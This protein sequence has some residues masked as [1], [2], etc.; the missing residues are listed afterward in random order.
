VVPKG[1]H[2]AS[3]L[4]PRL[5]VIHRIAGDREGAGYDALFIVRVRMLLSPRDPTIPP[6]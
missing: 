2:T 3:H 5:E 6:P 1:L 4:R